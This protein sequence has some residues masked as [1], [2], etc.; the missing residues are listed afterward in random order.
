MFEPQPNQ[1]V[2]LAGLAYGRS[3]PGSAAQTQ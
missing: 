3:V 2:R 1:V